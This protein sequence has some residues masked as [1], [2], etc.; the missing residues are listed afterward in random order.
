M[1]PQQRANE[2]SEAE[3]VEGAGDGAAGDAVEAGEVPGDLGLVDGEVRGDGAVE[4]LGGEDGVG[5]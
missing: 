3:D 4:A 2:V 1:P 5:C